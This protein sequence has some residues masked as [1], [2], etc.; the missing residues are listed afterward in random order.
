M[1]E[2][3]PGKQFLYRLIV[4]QLQKDGFV[5]VATSL[6]IA[7]IGQTKIIPSDRL[8]NLISLCAQVVRDTD[9]EVV[10]D[11]KENSHSAELN[12]EGERVPENSLELRKEISR[13]LDN[14]NRP[15]ENNQNLTGEMGAQQSAFHP[16]LSQIIQ[17]QGGAVKEDELENKNLLNKG[18]EDMSAAALKS[19]H[20]LQMLKVFSNMTEATRQA[21]LQSQA[22]QKKPYYMS[23]PPAGG[24]SKEQGS[25]N[26]EPIRPYPLST[27]D[28][29]TPRCRSTL[30]PFTGASQDQGHNFSYNGDQEVKIENSHNI[31]AMEDIIKLTEDRSGLPAT[32][33]TSI[34]SGSGTN[35]LP[36][37]F[38]Q[39]DSAIQELIVQRQLKQR[40]FK[41]LDCSFVNKLIQQP[42]LVNNLV[43]SVPDHNKPKIDFNSVLSRL[44]SSNSE[45]EVKMGTSPPPSN[46]PP[47]LPQLPSPK[48]AT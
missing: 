2:L 17:N 9:A 15:Q 23:P 48:L 4:S 34:T 11:E 1:P 36:I 25:F 10:V 21:Y 29:K 31:N 27:P 16:A 35:N 5:N 33:T 28:I 42:N 39:T 46:I 32:T 19:L 47:P 18:G 24:F 40:R 13:T 43:N 38:L 8:H 41:D 22:L 37:S 12:G 3:R 30:L 7:T 20:H 45:S 14:N 26:K 44:S 6:S